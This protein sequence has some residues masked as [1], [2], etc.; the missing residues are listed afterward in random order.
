MAM[1]IQQPSELPQE[2]P[3]ATARE[4]SVENATGGETEALPDKETRGA[5]PADA[6]YREA[7][8]EGF[9]I[10]PAEQGKTEG[11]PSGGAAGGAPAEEWDED[12]PDQVQG[13]GAESNR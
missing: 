13:R 12:E 10:P 9:V 3:G 11:A 6:L 7:G 4:A 5:V 1:S 8:P 2:R